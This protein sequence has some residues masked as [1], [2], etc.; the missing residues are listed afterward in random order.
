CKYLPGI[1]LIPAPVQLFGRIAKL[2][3]EIARQVLGLSF[4]ALF[5]P[6]AEAVVESRFCGSLE[7]EDPLNLRARAAFALFGVVFGVVFLI[8][9][10]LAAMGLMAESCIVLADSKVARCRSAAAISSISVFISLVAY[11]RQNSRNGRLSILTS[12]SV[13]PLGLYL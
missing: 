8:S 2:D 5:P 11:R 3:D 10:R 13:W 1:G 6:E 12:L 9:P 7:T 4:A